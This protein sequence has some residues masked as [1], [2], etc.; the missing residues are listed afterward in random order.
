MSSSF[1]TESEFKFEELFFSR[2]NTRGI[3][4]S[5]NSVFQRVSKYEWEELLQKP[6][7]I[8]RHPAMPRGVFQLFWDELLSNNQLLP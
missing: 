2:T 6:H 3:I 5:A 7:K 8:I 4:Q 1:G